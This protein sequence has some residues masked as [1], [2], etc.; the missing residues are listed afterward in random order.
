MQ[1]AGRRIVLFSITFSACDI[2]SGCGA[3]A[4][5]L[6]RS[7]AEERDLERLLLWEVAGAVT[8][9]GGDAD[10]LCLVSLRIAVYWLH[11][12]AGSLSSLCSPEHWF[13]AT[14]ALYRY[15][16]HQS[17]FC[18]CFASVNHLGYR[19]SLSHC[20]S[21]WPFPHIFFLLLVFAPKGAP[22][23]RS[24]YCSYSHPA[25]VGTASICRC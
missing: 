1:A 14:S 12:L 21:V 8:T 17:L 22:M 19:Y 25:V 3:A 15:P 7:G 24:L 16:W 23:I 9:S 6:L 13:I 18:L 4:P 10:G 5:V 20:H 11:L 2:G